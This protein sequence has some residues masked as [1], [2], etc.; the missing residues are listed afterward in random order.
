MSIS[1]TDGEA[2]VP[3]SV[4]FPYDLQWTPFI[5]EGNATGDAS[6]GTASIQVPVATILPQGQY[7]AVGRINQRTS[8]GAANSTA[9]SIL[10]DKFE[11]MSDQYGLLYANDLIGD[12]LGNANYLEEGLR[13]PI[14]LGQA[15]GDG[16]IVIAWNSNQDGASY[17]VR[18]SG[19]YSPEPF[20]PVPGW[21]ENIRSI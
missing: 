4:K 1:V 9:N 12:L 18:I 10:F 11:D 15:L 7:I 13:Y 8:S 5:I 21:W 17:N 3:R 16:E 6:G 19:V 2:R 20:E 14:V